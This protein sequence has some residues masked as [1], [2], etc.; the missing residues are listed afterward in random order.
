MHKVLFEL[1]YQNCY[2]RL[3]D[4]SYKIKVNTE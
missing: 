1:T 2:T 3:K 4:K